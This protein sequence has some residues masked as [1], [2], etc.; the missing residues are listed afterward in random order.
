MIR[1]TYSADK[2]EKKT[3]DVDSLRCP[4]CGKRIADVM[5]V[6]GVF[7]LNVKCTRCGRFFNAEVSQG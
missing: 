1:V 7:T 2:G 5:H 3:E 4:V 6:D